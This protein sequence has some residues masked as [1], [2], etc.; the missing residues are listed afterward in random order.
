L[1]S[2]KLTGRKS[3]KHFFSWDDFGVRFLPDPVAEYPTV[4]GTSQLGMPASGPGGI[5]GSGLASGR[6][7]RPLGL[8]AMWR[9]AS[10]ARRCGPASG[11]Q[12]PPQSFRLLPGPAAA[13][14]RGPHCREGPAVWAG[15]TLP[16]L[17][18]RREKVKLPNEP[19]LAG[20]KKLCRYYGSNIIQ[21]IWL[22]KTDGFVWLR[23]GFTSGLGRGDTATSFKIPDRPAPPANKK[24]S[25]LSLAPFVSSDWF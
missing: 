10:L 24:G 7:R 6:W 1:R 22:P 17:T 14:R 3:F 20:R 18:A 8:P 5:R 2:G 19:N 21:F 11:R 16:A 23:S 9:G 13:G 4:C 12:I 15:R 25:K